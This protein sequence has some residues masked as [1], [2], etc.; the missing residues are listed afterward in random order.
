MFLYL[1]VVPKVVCFPCVNLG[2]KPKGEGI[3]AATNNN[4]IIII[5]PIVTQFTFVVDVIFFLIRQ[6]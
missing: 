1:T 4:Q 2:I 6:I 3:A 5:G